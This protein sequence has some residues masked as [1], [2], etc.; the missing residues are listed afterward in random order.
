MR[1]A[2]SELAVSFIDGDSKIFICG[3]GRFARV[4]IDIKVGA[5]SVR[6]ARHIVLEIRLNMVIIGIV[7]CIYFIYSTSLGGCEDVLSV[8]HASHT[9]CV[10]CG[11]CI[12][13]L[14]YVSLGSAAIVG[15]QRKLGAEIEEVSI[16]IVITLVLVLQR[17]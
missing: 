16:L 10:G 13:G 1:R 6:S 2:N 14:E 11:V 12:I 15:G 9:C 3:S 4:T 8:G 7:V 17:A 5:P